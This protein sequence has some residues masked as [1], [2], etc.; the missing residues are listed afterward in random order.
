MELLMQYKCYYNLIQT[1][2]R[3]PLRYLGKHFALGTIISY[4]DVCYFIL[5][6]AGALGR[7]IP[8]PTPPGT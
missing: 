5:R 7:E 4:K 6:S 1:E 3:A 2:N 8:V